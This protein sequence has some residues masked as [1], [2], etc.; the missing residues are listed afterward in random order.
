[1]EIELTQGKVAMVDDEDFEWLTQWK[2]CAH[3]TNG[4]WYAKSGAKPSIR[5]HQLLLDPPLGYQCDHIN[6]DGLDNRR[7][8]LRL[9]TSSQNQQNRKP[10]SG[11]TSKF[12][13]VHWYKNYKRWMAGIQ[14]NQERIF[15]GYFHSE[16]DAAQAYDKAALKYFGGFA[17]TN[18][19]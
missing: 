12:K 4:Y 11:G 3:N 13:G 5:M 8:N 18:K 7:V 9:C 6:N 19:E 17:R 14:I 2:W 1:M 15:L 10:Q 16:I